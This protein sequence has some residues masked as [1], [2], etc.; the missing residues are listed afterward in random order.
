[1]KK[2]LSGAS[3]STMEETPKWALYHL[4]GLLSALVVAWGY[5]WLEG[6]RLAKKLSAKGLLHIH[7]KSSHSK[8]FKRANFEL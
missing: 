1:M 8:H 4:N 7:F 2:A 3:S 5:G 6:S